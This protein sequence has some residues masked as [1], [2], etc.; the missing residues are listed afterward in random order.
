MNRHDHPTA[1]TIYQDVKVIY[2][3]I[4]L[5]TV[6]RNLAFLS[7]TGEI[8][9]IS[10][11]DGPDRF[12]GDITPHY[13]F[14]CRECGRMLDIR[15]SDM[16]DIETLNN[17]DIPGVVEDYSIQFRGRCSDCLKASLK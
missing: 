1:D 9:K 7:E 10:T 13:H 14:L 2:P 8:L 15:T 11:G 17:V 6:Y 4:S 12:D 16:I 5:G 3:N